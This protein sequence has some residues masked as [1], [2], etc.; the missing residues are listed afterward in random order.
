ML[1][2]RERWMFELIQKI[3][4][5]DAHNIQGDERPWLA[6]LD[7]SSADLLQQENVKYAKVEIYRYRMQD[8]LWAIAF[9]WLKA[10][11]VIWWNREF[12]ESL[13]SPVQVM[14]NGN[15]AYANV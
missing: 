9:K 11:E 3:L 6:L 14:H 12:E 13:I 1:Q 7:P 15:L 4:V 5:S 8:P 10:E 2:R